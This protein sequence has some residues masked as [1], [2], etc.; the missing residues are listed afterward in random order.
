MYIYNMKVNS[1]KIA[2]IVLILIGIIIVCIIGFSVFS[3]IKAGNKAKNNT[4]NNA[5]SNIIEITANE[6]TSFLKNAHENIDDYVGMKIKLTGYVYRMPDFND[7]QF[8]ISRTMILDSSST[9]VVVGILSEYENAKDY[10]DGDWVEV[11]GTIVR[12]NYKGEMPVIQINNIQSCDIPEDEYVYP[13]SE[14][15]VI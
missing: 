11:T 7:N 3:I 12:G 13:P 5:D 2:K 10:K 14:N 4:E 15:S 1:K 9:A 8:V 6:Y